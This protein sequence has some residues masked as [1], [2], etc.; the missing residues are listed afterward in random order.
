MSDIERETSHY[1]LLH[2]AEE[3]DETKRNGHVKS[4]KQIK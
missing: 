4:P 1:P 2:K 3:L